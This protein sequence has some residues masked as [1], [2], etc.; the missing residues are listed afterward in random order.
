MIIIIVTATGPIMQYD[1]NGLFLLKK[2]D[3]H[4]KKGKQGTNMGKAKKN[5]RFYIYFQRV[6]F[7]PEQT[8]SNNNGNDNSNDNKNQ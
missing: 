7:L 3:K 2:A 6:S 5:K 8:H 1:S 4:L